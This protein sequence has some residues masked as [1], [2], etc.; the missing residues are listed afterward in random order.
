[1]PPP[2]PPP[3][4]S[5][6]VR[7]K[8]PVRIVPNAATSAAAS[9]LFT[10]NQPS[11]NYRVRWRGKITEEMPISLIL[12][13]TETGELGM[14][15]QIEVNA[16]WLTIR[17]F[18][19]EHQDSEKE[20]IA[21]ATREAEAERARRNEEALLVAAERKRLAE[22]SSAEHAKQ[23][24]VEIHRREKQNELEIHRRDIERIRAASFASN[25]GNAMA[26]TVLGVIACV[27]WFLV[28]DPLNVRG[29]SIASIERDVGVS[30]EQK[31]RKSVGSRV[32]VT[33]VTLIRKS[34]NEL[35]GDAQVTGYVKATIH[36]SVVV[37][38]AAFQWKAEGF[39]ID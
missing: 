10:K 29:P 32:A 8:I 5:I 14:L 37:D 3:P 33:K 23:N 30:L 4:P 1:M 19:T 36:L 39:E 16:R 11:G 9:Q 2:P 34:K 25:R 18:L 35:V 7:G 26:A 12:K 24:E 28:A 6:P 38:G 27:A 21:T 15:T 17:D 31:L 13:K 22:E 20:R